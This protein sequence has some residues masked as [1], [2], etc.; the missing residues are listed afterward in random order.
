MYQGAEPEPGS[1]IAE[2]E[3]LGLLEELFE[4][5][6]RARGCP[7]DQDLIPQALGP[8]PHD[9]RSFLELVPEITVAHGTNSVPWGPTISSPE[10]PKT[11]GISSTKVGGSTGTGTKPPCTG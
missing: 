11:F 3:E 5:G 9:F 1:G 6:F 4:L 7:H 2:A 10:S 8:R